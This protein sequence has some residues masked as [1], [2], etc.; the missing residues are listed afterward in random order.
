MARDEMRKLALENDS[1]EINSEKPFLTTYKCLWLRWPN[2]ETPVGVTSE[3][4]GSGAATQLFS[5]IAGTVAG[6]YIPLETP[7]YDRIKFTK[8]D[9][10]DIIEV[11][12]HLP[13]TKDGKITIQ[14]AWD[15]RLESALVS[16]E[17]GVLQQWSWGG[18]VALVGDAAHKFTPSTGA[19]C[20]S[21]MIDVVALVNNLHRLLNND[22]DDKPTRKEIQGAFDKYQDARLNETIFQCKFS[23]DA[24]ASASWSSMFRRVVDQYV[25]PIQ[26]L[27]KYLMDKAATRIVRS[28]AFEF[29]PQDQ[30]VH[31]KVEW[32]HKGQP[33]AA[34]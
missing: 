11:W 21:G 7:T 22:S 12:G 28:P 6:I 18:K 15:Q 10:G 3:T 34:L 5:G 16:L 2:G 23:G 25:M 1:A 9:E 19:G 32:L 30:H 13:L 31:G 33:V 14:S 8:K 4:H 26:G 24:T 29:L 27:Q 20:N 17:E